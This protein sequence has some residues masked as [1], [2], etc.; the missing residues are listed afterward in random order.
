MNNLNTYILYAVLTKP[1]SYK[2]KLHVKSTGTRNAANEKNIQK[3]NFTS[4]HY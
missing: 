2:S 3:F 1:Q 4:L